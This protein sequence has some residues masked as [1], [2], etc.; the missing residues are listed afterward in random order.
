[1]EKMK[2]IFLGMVVLIIAIG[3]VACSDGSNKSNTKNADQTENYKKTPGKITNNYLKIGL[4]VRSEQ[5]IENYNKINKV[6]V[7]EDNIT[8][9]KLENMKGQDDGK[10]YKNVYSIE[11]Q[12][13]WHDK[14]YD[15]STIVSFKKNNVDD[16]MY[17]LK[18]SSETTGPVVD[19][20]L[21]PVK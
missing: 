1:M 5:I 2:K 16:D 14:R 4:A 15:F 3:L 13:S 11:G 17:I 20:D 21:T 10:V 18:Y 7:D 6:R 19:V 8:A 9:K 12:Y